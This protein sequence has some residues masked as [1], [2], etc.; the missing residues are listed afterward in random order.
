MRLFASLLKTCL[1]HLIEIRDEQH[2]FRRNRSTTNAIFTIQQVKEK[3][4]ES[5]Q[6]AYTRFIDLTKVINRVQLKGLSRILKRTPNTTG[7][8]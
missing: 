6:A 2:V 1:E 8:H 4:I 3:V 7:N 5:D